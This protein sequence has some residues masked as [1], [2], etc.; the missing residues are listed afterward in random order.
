MSGTQ[1]SFDPER[2]QFDLLHAFL[3][4]SYWSPGISMELMRRGFLSSLP[5]GA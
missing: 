1:L 5:V 3:R 2:F 4:A